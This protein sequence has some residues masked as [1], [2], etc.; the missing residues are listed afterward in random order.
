MNH[1]KLAAMLDGR[2]VVLDAKNA[3]VLMMDARTEQ[4]WRAC[5]DLTNEEI[6][7]QLGDSL[8]SVM[9]TLRK[10]AAVGL[11]ACDHERWRQVDVEWV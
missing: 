4:V 9:S 3:H 5:R 1:T 7:A 11:V 6:A 8:S 2:V 10:L